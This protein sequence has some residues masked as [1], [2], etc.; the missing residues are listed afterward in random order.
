[1]F[2]LTIFETSFKLFCYTL[3]QLISQLPI[4]TYDDEDD[5]DDDDDHLEGVDSGWLLG[6]CL[7]KESN[8]EEYDISTTR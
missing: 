3:L 4:F 2:R 5:D 8:T 7:R 6:L 1:M